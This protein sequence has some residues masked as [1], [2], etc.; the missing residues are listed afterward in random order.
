[1]SRKA[2]LSI[3]PLKIQQA[4]GGV[5]VSVTV[6]GYTLGTAPD[7]NYWKVRKKGVTLQ[8]DLPGPAL[9]GG[10]KGFSL[11]AK[12]TLPEGWPKEKARAQVATCF[13]DFIGNEAALARI[14]PTIVEGLMEGTFRINR[15]LLLVGNPG[16]GKTELAHRTAAALEV[17]LLKIDGKTL[18]NREALFD[19][20]IETLRAAR[21][22]PARTGKEGGKPVLW[23]PPLVI[24]IDE[25]HLL[26]RPAQESLLTA[27]DP[28]VRRALLADRILDTSMITWLLTT[29]KP[30]RLDPAF[31]D[32]CVEVRLEDY[33][34]AEVAQIVETKRSTGWGEAVLERLATLGRLSPRFAL[35]LADDV[36]TRLKVH[37]ETP[38]VALEAARVSWSIDPDGL[39]P[40]DREYLRTLAAAPR[41]LGEQTLLNQLPTIDKAA[42]TGAVEPFLCRLGYLQLGAD[43]RELTPTGRTRSEQLCS[44]KVASDAS[45]ATSPPPAEEPGTSST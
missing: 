24:C 34:A 25:V 22:K 45:S 30:S 19:R 5:D 29:T 41:P 8:S 6:A 18:T 38:E 31:V 40:A 37:D 11:P 42:V 3:G 16:V 2:G 4:K 9:G 35:K 7:G 33:T 23:L 1:M 26:P 28:S 12:V 15:N 27:L 10:L 43:G 20:A 21:Q 36:A 44:T 14:A 39:G 13:K 32:R 17:P